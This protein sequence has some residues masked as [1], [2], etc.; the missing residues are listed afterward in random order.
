AALWF[1]VRD[2]PKKDRYGDPAPGVVWCL[3]VSE[4]DVLQDDEASTFQPLL[5]KRT[6]LVRPRHIAA[7]ILAQSGWFT[8]HAWRRRDGKVVPVE[9]NRRFKDRLTKVLIPPDAFPAL[10]RMLETS[11]IS[12]AT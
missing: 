4:R 5:T 11:N 12:H 7:R 9:K 6:L 2:E 1:A 3:P 8:L 10:R